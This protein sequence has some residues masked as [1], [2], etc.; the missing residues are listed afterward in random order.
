MIRLFLAA[1]LY[2]YWQVQNV[3]DFS[4]LKFK[5]TNSS[6]FVFQALKKQNLQQTKSFL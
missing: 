2:K 1:Y 3:N 5:L 4:I 6:I